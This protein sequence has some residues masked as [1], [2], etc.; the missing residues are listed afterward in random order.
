MGASS[1]TSLFTINAASLVVYDKRNV[2]EQS[3]SGVSVSGLTD[4]ASSL[5][6][7][8]TDTTTSSGVSK[9][10]FTVNFDPSNVQFMSSSNQ[11]PVT[12]LA[13]SNQ[14]GTQAESQSAEVP[15]IIM[16]TTL[17]F[18]HTV[19]SNAF[20]N[21]ILGPSISTVAGSISSL[22]GTV[23]TVRDEVQALLG[24][25]YF[26]TTREV[27]FI[28]GDFSF[29][30]QLIYLNSQYTMF[31]FDGKPVRAQ[32]YLRIS[33]GAGGEVLS[34]WQKQYEATFGAV[35]SLSNATDAVSSIL[36]ISL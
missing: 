30:G 24:A 31:N 23:R 22:A 18:D 8:V 11:K 6:D 27:E 25:M 35:T 19:N 12:N 7:G 5:A 3:S 17:I 9:V 14:E 26:A 21:D 1:F 20:V 15:T 10:T 16:S 29:K 33:Q 28:W 34:L 13:T 36:N 32:V 2:E 4:V